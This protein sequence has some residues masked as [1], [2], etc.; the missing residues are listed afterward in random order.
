MAEE[1]SDA[2]TAALYVLGRCR[3][4]DAWSQQTL[5][6]AQ[7]KFSLSGRDSALCAN[8]CLAVLRN[9][10]LC[11]YYID[12]FSAT[13]SAKLQPQIRDI[14][15]LGV[16][17]LLFLDR[18]PASA[19]VHSSVELAK[20]TNPRAAGLVNAVLRRV[21]ER[22]DDLPP[23][24][25]EG[26]AR[27]LSVRYSHPLWLCEKLTA[28]YG[29]DFTRDY[30]AE[31]NR[32]SDWTL[33]VNLCRTTAE[34]LKERLTDR[35]LDA[36]IS[37]LSPLS[38]TVKRV[39][40]VTDLPGFD[41]GDFFVQDAAAALAVQLARP[42]SGM[43]VLDACAAPGG[44]SFL[45]ASLMRDEGEIL[46]CDLHAKKLQRIEDGAQRLGFRSIRTAPMDASKP[47]ANLRESFDLVLSDVP[48]SGLGVIRKKPEIRYKD[49]AELAALPAIQ[50]RILRGLAECVKPGGTLLY[51]TCTVLKEENEAVVD[52]F[53]AEDKRFS[54]EEQRT[55]WP[56]THGTDGF[57]ICRLIRNG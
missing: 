40:S 11:D 28:E 31:N 21:A 1:R 37:E 12:C 45:C 49:E 50:G 44:K 54:R 32:E 25:D 16:S 18:I 2:R 48:C 34:E 4:F 9:A 20:R 22:R 29:Y 17:Q 57:F 38:V 42:K 5:K 10:A 47:Y 24:P 13:K 55:L 27:E 7:E 39:G 36:E 51:S 14:L 8:L 3:R 41:T 46:S 53:L 52:A 33:S 19:A 23:V 43:R 15:R 26:T 6:A 30:L 35:G 56:Q